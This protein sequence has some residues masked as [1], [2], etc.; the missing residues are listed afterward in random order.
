MFFGNGSRSCTELVSIPVLA[1]FN[2]RTYTQ[3][4]TPPW[5]N[6]GGGEVGWNPFPEFLI[7]CS[8]S[9]RFCLQSKTFDL[10]NEARYISR[11]CYRPVTPPIMFAIFAPSCILP[12]TGNQVK[13]ARNGTFCA[14]H[15]K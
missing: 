5:Y 13:T 12:R 15:E 10:L 9:E 11:R 6:G 4:H 7:C 3:I 1:T 2:P 8:I 14:L